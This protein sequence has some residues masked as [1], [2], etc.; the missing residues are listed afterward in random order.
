M[1]SPT[2]PEPLLVNFVNTSLRDILNFIGNSTG[3]NVTFDRDF[4]DRSITVKLEDVSLEQAL[5]QIMIANQLFYKVLNERTIIVATDSTAKR[6][7]VR[8]AGHPDLL[9]LA[10]RRHRAGAAA[11]RR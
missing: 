9:R 11:D 1:L 4:Q 5:Q 3:I 8:R 7:A 10:R 2:N 6:A